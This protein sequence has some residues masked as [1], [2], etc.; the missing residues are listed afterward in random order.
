MID[1]KK[2]QDVKYED[3]DEIWCIVRFMKYKS[4]K[5]KH[6]TA[7]SPSTTLFQTFKELQSKGEWNEK[8]F[9]NVYVPA[10]IKQMKS[11]NED[12]IKYLNELYN[13]D[14]QNK[15][16]C[17]VCFCQDETMCHRSI[18]AGLLQGVGCKV[19]ITNDNY[20]H[21]YDMYC[22]LEI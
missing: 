22:N 6:I 18:I 5:M 12:C 8:T 19:N 14:K 2:I 16:I 20:Y 13:L 15:K 7:L 17:L 1:I 3:Y 11:N 9:Q 4:D 10:F 21:Y